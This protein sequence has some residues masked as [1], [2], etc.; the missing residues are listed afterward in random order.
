[1]SLS[2]W[3]GVKKF[4]TV[5]V[6]QYVKFK[7]TKSHI[8]CFSGKIGRKYGF[9]FEPLEERLNTRFL[10]RVSDLRHIWEPYRKLDVLCLVFLDAR[11]SIELQNMSCFGVKN[12]FK[13]TSLGWK[14]FARH[15]KDRELYTFNDK[16]FR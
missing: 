15:N 9:Q 16:Y 1:M 7:C 3:C 11:H 2:I 6:L 4:I 5:E 12:C 10:L 14:C 8:K 13:E